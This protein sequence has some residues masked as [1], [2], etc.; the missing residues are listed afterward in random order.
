MANLFQQID[1][2]SQINQKPIAIKLGWSD[3][4]G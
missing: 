2:S 4:I 1:P 3:F